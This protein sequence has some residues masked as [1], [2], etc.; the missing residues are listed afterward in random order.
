MI[1]KNESGVILRCLDSVR[2]LIDYVLIEDTGSTDG[3]QDAIA[4]WLAQEKL[5]GRVVEEPWQNFAYNRSHALAQLRHVRQV[6]Y[7]LIMDAD[8]TLVFEG[9]FD[10]ALFKSALNTDIYDTE[11]RHG[12]STFMRPQLCRN[13]LKFTFKAVLHEYLEAPEGR[14]S[15]ATAEGFFIDVGQGGARSQNPK[16][17]EDD[18]QSLENALATEA[19]PFLISRYTFYLAQSYRDCGQADKALVNYLKR[20]ELGFWEEEVF[21]S[22]YEA[23]KLKEGLGFPADEVLASFVK[24]ADALATRAEALH[25]AAKFCRMQGRNHDAL[26]YARRGLVLP[27]PR[28]GLFVQRWIYD[29]GLLDEFAI[30]AYWAGEYRESLDACLRLL[31]SPHLPGSERDRVC[32]NARFAADKLP[33]P[34]NLGVLGQKSLLDRHAITAHPRLHSQTTQTPHVMLAILAKQKEE[35]LPFYLECID[36]LDYPKRAISLYIRTN[37][38]TDGTERILREWVERAGSHYASVEF[39]ASDVPEPVETFAVHEWNPVRFRVLGRIRNISLRRAL[40]KDC[41]FYFVADVDNFIHPSTLTELVALNLPITAPLLR[42]IEAGSYYSNYH[43]EIDDRGY[44]R[45]CDQYHWL[46]NGYV[47]GIVEVPVVHCTYLIRADVLTQLTYEDETDRHEYVV[48]S[49]SARKAGIPQ[50]LDTRVTY[51]YLVFGQDDP[52]YV[53]D[54]IDRARSLLGSARPYADAAIGKNGAAEFPVPSAKMHRRRQPEDA[55]KTLLFCTSFASSRQHWSGRYHRWLEAIR[56][57]ELKYH[58]ILIADDGS[59]ILPDWPDAE[60]QT[61]ASGE[62]ALK[63][64]PPLLIYHFRTHLGRNSV[65]DFPGWY[66]SFAFAGRFAAQNGFEKVIHVESDSFL[67]GTRVQR[68]FNEIKEGWTAL[69][70]PSY[71]GYAESALQVVAGDAIMRFAALEKTHPHDNLI[72]REFERQLPF[73]MVEKRFLGDRYGEY[74]PF[75]PGN[76]EYVVSARDDQ[77]R[78]YYWWLEQ[79]RVA[80]YADHDGS[81]PSRL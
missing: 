53:V 34:A 18:A 11:I 81:L 20:S 68:Y 58:S 15:R 41:A 65:F 17:Y 27:V 77:S 33:S 60:I 30:N 79:G 67:I 28:T 29:Y 23:A 13:R 75:V 43:A 22:L 9:G 48:F 40:E 71:G 39:D 62:D 51:G 44:Y 5:P 3:T 55:P 10:V 61:E 24:A 64:I 8:D 52:H 80:E 7:A 69:W 49:D 42:S 26:H 50:Y 32:A 63:T 47:R 1:V 14:L 36:K 73:D 54:A 25:G 72:G 37:N 35:A 56:S 70:C 19:D 16:K 46:L 57:S 4:N 74:L 45:E 38:N 12:A 78:D 2:P 76:A 31:G 59:R 6:D 21:E 66:R